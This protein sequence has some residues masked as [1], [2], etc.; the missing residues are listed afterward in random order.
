MKRLILVVIALFITLFFTVSSVS[1]AVTFPVN[2]GTGISTIPTYGQVLV[3]NPGGTYTLTATSSLGILGGVSSVFGRTGA[4][5]AQSGDYSAFYSPILVFSYPLVNTAN[6]I[7]L[8]FGT[9]TSNTWA[10]VQTFTNAPIFSSLTGLLKGNGSSAITVG[11]NGTDYTLNTAKTCSAGDF[12]SAVTAAGV[13][14]CTTPSGTTYTGSFP[15]VVTGSV[16]SFSGLTTSTPGVVGNI[17]YFTSANAFANVAT[18]TLT[19]TAPLTGSFTHVG[20]TGALGCQTASG[21]QAGCLSSTDWTTFNSKV[22]TSR[23]LTAGA[24]LIGGGDLSADRTFAIDFTR[25]N[26]WTGLQTFANSSTTLASIS[27]TLW[28]TPLGTAA[29]AF[30]AV[31]ANGKVIATT[32]PSS[33]GVT[34]V[35][36][37][38]NQITSSGGTTPVL[39]LPSLVIFPNAA[40]ST[41]FS[42]VGTAYFGGTATTTIDSGGNI[43]IPSTASFTLTGRLNGC[44]FISSAVLGSTGTTCGT[45]TGVTGTYPVQ[46]TGGAAPAISLAFGTTT[47]NIWAGNQTFTNGMLF[48]GSSSPSYTQGRLLYDTA[49]ESLTFFN[50]DSNISLQIGQE[51]WTRVWNGTGSTITNGSA[52][53]TNGSHGTLPSVALSDASDSTK[54]V[55]MGLATEDIANNATGTITTI[56]VVHGLNTSGFTAGANVFVSAVT[57]GALTS[58]A[59]VSPNYRYRVGVVTVSDAT[60]GSIQ[61][62]PT[63]AAVGNGTAGQFLGINASAKQAF[64][65]FSYPLLSTGT[66]VSLA[67]GTTTANTWALGQTFTSG[68]VNSATSTGTFGIN[69]SGGCF[70]I[71]GTCI[72]GGGG[73]VSSVSNSDGTLTISPTTGSVVASIALSHANAWTG[74][75]NFLN[76]S[77][78]IFS[79]FNT[80]YFGGTSTTTING[81]G[82]TST[83]NGSVAIATTSPNAL[84]VSDAFN[85]KY[86]TVTTA[87]TTGN[88]F[89]VATSTGVTHFAIDQKGHYITGGTAPA[90][91]AC[92][93]TPAIS[94]NDQS[95]TVTIG[96][97]S[98]T[99][100][101]VTFNAAYATTPHCVL[102]DSSASI[103]SGITA[104]TASA[105]TAGFSLSLASGFFNY[106]CYQ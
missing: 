88:I 56:G 31:D 72:G 95:G 97:G 25:A 92:G 96:T 54:I 39:S 37:T 11:V 86:F 13:F 102:I 53:Y 40:S 35:S 27:G 48:T 30:L 51:E 68:F 89:E 26:S 99:A 4:V 90:V 46:S 47:S 2:G 74:L 106:I 52:V 55:T 70:A 29:G 45:V 18:S 6:T 7:S 82:A 71:S 57:P 44:A 84:Q 94:G 63:T 79:V 87:S 83:F 75:Q 50:N 34:S 12:I 22:G 58:T 38:T 17:P 49:N 3:G 62:T 32:T 80:G 85:S 23:T 67:F 14:T 64:L 73:A 100:C 19:A 9:T 103:D 20:T 105:F 101:T 16:I 1:A 61:V 93:T 104:Q 77:S 59:P 81:N 8:A 98:V 36:G 66:G 91:S 10:N 21:S 65:G 60:I 42:N 76:A 78:S 28:I 24:G 69:L 41:L 5:T 43:T 15:I 33:S